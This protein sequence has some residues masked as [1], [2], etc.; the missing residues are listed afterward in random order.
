MTICVR[1]VRGVCAADLGES[2]L[3]RIHWAATEQIA[4]GFWEHFPY[5]SLSSGLVCTASVNSVKVKGEAS[6]HFWPGISQLLTDIFCLLIGHTI[7]HKGGSYK[8]IPE[9]TVE[10]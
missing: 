10:V 7:S 6:G 4:A 5:C 1:W 8:Y 2:G 3:S 9:Q